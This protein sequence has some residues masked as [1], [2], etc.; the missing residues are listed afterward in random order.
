[1][2]SARDFEMSLERTFESG[3]C[4][5]K[6][7]LVG[8]IEPGHDLLLALKKM[9]EDEGIEGGFILSIIGSLRRAILRNVARFPEQLP[10]TDAE[11]LY[12]EVKGPLEILSASGTIARGDGGSFI[13]AHI[14]VS[15]VVDGEVMVF[16]GHLTEGCITWVNVEIVLAEVEGI[17]MR[18]MTHGER[19]TSELF[20]FPKKV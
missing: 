13:H 3:N 5:I 14:C 11:R 19:K 15:K 8:K 4:R 9:V 6:R 18:R 2:E 7:V 1:M 17:E 16:G 10:V 12:K 20:I